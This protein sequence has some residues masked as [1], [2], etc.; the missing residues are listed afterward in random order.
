MLR[1]CFIAGLAALN[2]M[3]ATYRGEVD[4]GGLPLPGATVT[5]SRDGQKLT[6]VT[7]ARGA[8]AFPDLTD[9]PWKIRIEMLCFAPVAADV[10][11]ANDTPAGKWE[12]KLLP[13]DQIKSAATEM[14][15]LPHPAA[16][17]TTSTPPGPEAAKKPAPAAPP[18]APS[19]PPDELSE[20]A[21]DGLLVNGTANNGASS[22]FA[23]AAA[24][25]NSR[26]GNGGLFTGGIGMILDNSTLDARPFS[27]TGQD[28]P[29]PAYDHVQGVATLGGVIKIPH[30][31]PHGPVFF[32]AY[33]WTRD[34]D[35]STLSGLVPGSLLRGGIFGAPVQILDPATGAPFPGNQ[36]P[37]SR[38]SPQA[39]A[40]LNL[41]PLPNFNGSSSYNYQIPAL[42]T[43]HQDALQSRLNKT[44]DNHNQFY[45]GFAFQSSRQ[46]TPNLF[47]FLDTTDTLGINTNVHWQHMFK[48]HLYGN[49]GYTFSRLAT[50]VTP[51]FANRENI[52][53]DAGI[54]GNNQEPVNWGP[55]SLTFSSGISPLSDAQPLS[56]R[57]QTSAVSESVY[58]NYGRHNMTLGGDFRRQEF[59]YLSQQNP[60]GGFTFTGAAAG[61]DFADFLL[62]IPDASTIAFGNADK[63]FRGSS[64]DAYVTDDLRVGPELTVNAG[65]RWEYG[66][67]LT[68]LQGRLVNL[69]VAPGFAAVVPVTGI[70][71][72][73]V[74]TSQHYPDS[75]LHPDKHA[76]QPRDRYRVASDIRIVAGGAR[77]IRHRVQHVGVPDDRHA[78][79]ATGAPF[80][81]PE[82][83]EQRGRS[84]DAGQRVQCFAGHYAGY[85]WHRS[86]FPD[87]LCT[88]LECFGAA[89][90]AGV[91]GA[92]GDLPGHQGDARRAGVSAEHLS[93]GRHGPL[94]GVPAG[95]RLHDFERQFHARIG[96]DPAA[97]APALRLYGQ[98]DIHVCEIDRRCGAGGP[99]AGY[100]RDRAE[101]AGP[102]RGTRAIEFRSAPLVQRAD[103]IH[104]RHGAERADERLAGSAVQRMDGS[105]ADHCRE[106]PAA[107]AQ[108]P[109]A[110]GG[111]RY[112][113]DHPAGLHGRSTL[114]GSGRP[115]P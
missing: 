26:L 78:D 41:Y 80:E 101:L 104:Q 47:G 43:M 77:G 7:D 87:R 74:L 10:N 44:V 95:L 91:A 67:P 31:M 11:V 12:M 68:E 109:G 27:L 22:P 112:D 92:D 69:D 76:I 35:A 111:H 108:L 33:Q 84:A 57:N 62:G 34:H 21:S 102:E 14:A 93:R 98:R 9:V 96:T 38:I 48:P 85:V 16:S 46:D 55:P 36:L 60:R 59:N 71:P 61:A 94:S 100:G 114:R 107:D 1:G 83:A 89:R 39:R 79:G 90:P 4:F 72:V 8:Y 110:G 3:A 51:F 56:N 75:L 32:V 40:L 17:T 86:E 28:T 115:V 106:R 70:D 53:G 103:P 6:A 30:I 2:L 81:E 58:W 66:S 49:L 50:H 25:G 64:Y 23:Q 63:Y 97:A 99:R 82:R 37:Q 88:E 45:G 52:S 5:M 20:Q 73:G 105:L 113:G 19:Q 24:F 18:A 13:L 65:V 42:D 29:K 54:A 15:A